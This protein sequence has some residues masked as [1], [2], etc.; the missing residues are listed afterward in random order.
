[1]IVDESGELMLAM[2]S[3]WS[4]RNTKETIEIGVGWYK[5]LLLKMAYVVAEA[6]L[7]A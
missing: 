3:G 7:G 1:V 2:Q 5:K 6:K 4:G